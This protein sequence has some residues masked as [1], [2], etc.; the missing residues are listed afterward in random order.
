MATLGAVVIGASILIWFRGVPVGRLLPTEAR[1]RPKALG[2]P[3]QSTQAS[4]FRPSYGAFRPA[5]R[6]GND[7]LLTGAFP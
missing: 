5:R 2:S 6:R 1:G 3:F 4:Y 7:V